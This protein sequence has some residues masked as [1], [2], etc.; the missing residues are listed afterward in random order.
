MGSFS[1]S[2]WNHRSLAEQLKLYCESVGI[3]RSRHRLELEKG[4]EELEDR[5]KRLYSELDDLRYELDSAYKDLEQLRSEQDTVDFTKV[6]SDLRNLNKVKGVKIYKDCVEI[7]LDDLFYVGSIPLPSYILEIRYDYILKL[8]LKRGVVG[9]LHPSVP[10]TGDLTNIALVVLDLS[11]S[12]EHFD[13]VD[14]V[15]KLIKYLECYNFDHFIKFDSWVEHMLHYYIDDPS[16]T[17]RLLE[18]WNDIKE[19]V[20]NLLSDIGE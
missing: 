3:N 11:D 6:L 12:L 2:E 9:K 16:Y 19:T 20:R 14:V 7:E 4:L 10:R 8:K 18:A 5:R 1:K 17:K 15:T 13:L